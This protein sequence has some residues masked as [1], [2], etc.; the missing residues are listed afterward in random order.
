MQSYSVDHYIG[1]TAEIA[2]KGLQA[3]K[4]GDQWM[5]DVLRK[6]LV[7][8]RVECG[9]CARF[10]SSEEDPEAKDEELEEL[11]Y[12][13]LEIDV[14]NLS[15]DCESSV[16]PATAWNDDVWAAWA[17]R[18]DIERHAPVDDD[19]DLEDDDSDLE[20]DEV[21]NDNSTGYTSD[22]S[23]ESHQGISIL[24]RLR[25][26]NRARYNMLGRNRPILV[27]NDNS[28]GYTSDGSVEPS[29]VELSDWTEDEH[30]ALELFES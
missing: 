23:V 17:P 15:D 2:R 10:Y 4:A 22:G 18:R 9:Y 25:R 12:D 24:E 3:W 29:S 19:S 27:A 1:A 5:I 11:I 16:T 30:G 20:D 21:A 14:D 26:E 28:T 7:R 6:E 13:Q 8:V